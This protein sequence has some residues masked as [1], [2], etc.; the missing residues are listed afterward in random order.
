MQG[1][2]PSSFPMDQNVKLLR[3]DNTP[4]VDA[5]LYRRLVGRLLYLTVTRPDIT[6]AVNLLSQFLS[7]PRQSH[8]DAAYRVLRYLKSA[9][10][11]GIFLPAAGGFDLHAYCDADWGGCA[12]TRRSSSGYFI[13]LGGAPIL[14]CTK[15]QSVVARSSAEVEY[16]AM[17]T[18]VC[19]IVWL[20]WLLTDLRAAQLQATPLFCD[21]Q[22][23]RHI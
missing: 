3:D 2:R 7:C 21:N 19:E 1:S 23:A 20:R 4:E 14:W 12:T 11:Q 17:A 8:L 9:P 10:G 15:K 16:R 6:F 22:A 18:T 5:S 13:T